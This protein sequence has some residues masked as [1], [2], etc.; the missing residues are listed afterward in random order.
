MAKVKAKW[1]GSYPTLCFGKWTLEVDGKDVSYLI[2]EDKCKRPMDTFGMYQTW[3]FKNWIEQFESYE[4]G[5]EVDEWIL[6][7]QDWL[8][9]ITTDY[10]IQKQIFYA[11]SEQDFR[12][13]SCGG[14][15]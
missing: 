1:S 12:V 7:N 15:I 14:C 9:N 13:G 3:Y 11:I 8:D 5:L 10:N 4:S 2:P 6:E